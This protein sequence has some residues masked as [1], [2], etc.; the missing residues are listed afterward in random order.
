MKKKRITKRASFAFLTSFVASLLILAGLLFAPKGDLLKNPYNLQEQLI[1]EEKLLVDNERVKATLLGFA[2]GGLTQDTKLYLEFENK[3]DKELKSLIS[4]IAVNGMTVFSTQ[5]ELVITDLISPNS[6]K[7]YAMPCPASW[8][9]SVDAEKI[10][11]LLF[12]M[13]LFNNDMSGDT[14]FVPDIEVNTQHKDTYT[15]VIPEPSGKM[16]FSKEGLEV[17]LTNTKEDI[18][19]SGSA[20][21]YIKNTGDKNLVL[22]TSDFKYNGVD[23]PQAN[24]EFLVRANTSLPRAQITFEIPIDVSGELESLTS[25]A[26][27]W[28]YD[29]LKAITKPEPMDWLGGQHG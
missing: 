26:T 12:D 27:I 16:I 18:E 10:S 11:T 17:Y 19:N 13:R 25:L 8:L 9:K 6:K 7:I 28:H 1:T 20:T 2:E 29:E 3:T 22:K 23:F 5:S 15:Q 4:N 14:V 24:Y 21:L